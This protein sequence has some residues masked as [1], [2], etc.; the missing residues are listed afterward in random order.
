MS[1]LQDDDTKRGRRYST[2]HKIDDDAHYDRRTPGGVAVHCGRR[3]RPETAAI[4]FSG[5]I[6]SDDQFPHKQASPSTSQSSRS[7]ASHTRGAPHDGC[8]DGTDASHFPRTRRSFEP[9][10]A[11]H[12]FVMGGTVVNSI[13]DGN[14]QLVM[15][16]ETKNMCR[17]MES[18]QKQH[19]NISKPTSHFTSPHNMVT[20]YTRTRLP[21]KTTTNLHLTDSHFSQDDQRCDNSSSLS[22]DTGS[23]SLSNTIS[24]VDLTTW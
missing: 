8:D 21:D 18:I 9:I 16:D 11:V 1:S 23:F 3:R 13:R 5:E 17:V 7:Y 2:S 14:E 12:L 15:K 6:G 24:S 4:E 19:G 22:H 10:W 20:I